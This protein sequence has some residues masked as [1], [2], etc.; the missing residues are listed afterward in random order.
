MKLP[1]DERNP[2]LDFVLDMKKFSF[3][4]DNFFFRIATDKWSNIE[5]RIESQ[6][7]SK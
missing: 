4:E 5:V 6:K 2:F 3:N 1:I 7:I